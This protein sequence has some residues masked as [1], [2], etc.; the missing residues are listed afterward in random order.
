MMRSTSTLGIAGL[1]ALAELLR[2]VVGLAAARAQNGLRAF[3]LGQG[4]LQPGLGAFLAE[5]G[6]FGLSGFTGAGLAR[7]LLLRHL[8]LAL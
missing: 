6:Q 3:L 5:A 4:R 8:R 1:F 2:D 7:D